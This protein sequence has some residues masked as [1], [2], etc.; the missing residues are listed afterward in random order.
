MTKKLAV[1]IVCKSYILLFVEF[2][3]EVIFLQQ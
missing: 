1:I 2:S 3:G